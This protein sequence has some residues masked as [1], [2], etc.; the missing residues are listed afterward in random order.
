MWNPSTCDCECNKACQIDECQNPI[1]FRRCM[2]YN[3]LVK[4]L[5][6]MLS[7]TSEYVKSYDGQTK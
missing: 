2:H 1:F 6:I 4:V 3:P 5:H 7:K